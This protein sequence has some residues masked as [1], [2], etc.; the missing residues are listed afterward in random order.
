MRPFSRGLVRARDHNRRP[1][2]GN[3]GDALR[4]APG[5]DDAGFGLV[6]AG[7]PRSRTGTPSSRLDIPTKLD[8]VLHEQV[9]WSS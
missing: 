1:S 3:F 7:D 2:S 4:R 5:A 8:T 9:A 6:E